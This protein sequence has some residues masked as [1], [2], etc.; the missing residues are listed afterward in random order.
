MCCGAV[1]WDEG[2]LLLKSRGPNPPKALGE[3]SQKVPGG[4]G[5]HGVGGEASGFPRLLGPAGWDSPAAP[6]SWVQMS[7]ILTHRPAFQKGGTA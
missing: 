5:L 4:Q 7:G 3:L 6:D 2:S 1:L